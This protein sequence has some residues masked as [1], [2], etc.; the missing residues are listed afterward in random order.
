VNYLRDT[1][2]EIQALWDQVQPFEHET[3]AEGNRQVRETKYDESQDKALYQKSEPFLRELIL[4]MEGVSK[5]MTMRQDVYQTTENAKHDFET[6]ASYARIGDH[7]MA[8]LYQSYAL[9]KIHKMLDSLTREVNSQGRKLGYGYDVSG[10]QGEGGGTSGDGRHLWD[11]GN[12]P[13]RN[14]TQNNPFNMMVDAEAESDYPE[15][16]PFKHKHIHWPPRTR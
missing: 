14:H 16:V 15:L 10:E 2:S 8:T 4:G 6:G 1:Y 5:Q 11:T 12:S 9:M 7:A 3:D 13:K